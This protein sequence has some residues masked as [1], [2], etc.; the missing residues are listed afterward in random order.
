M[1][2]VLTVRLSPDDVPGCHGLPDGSPDHSKYPRRPAY[3]GCGRPSQ[4]NAKEAGM[5]S[6]KF[7]LM[8]VLWLL[9]ASMVGRLFQN[10]GI[11]DGSFFH[12]LLGTA[13][14]YLGM[15]EQATHFF[16]LYRG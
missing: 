6:M 9:V 5:E 3:R 12:G 2:P 15:E 16:R 8:A 11:L 1:L 7:G 14:R 4:T 13:F 10:M